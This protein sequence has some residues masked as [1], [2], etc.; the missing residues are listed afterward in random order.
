MSEL[1]EW[2]WN[3]ITNYQ[4]DADSTLG[5]FNIGGAGRWQDKAAIGLPVAFSDV[6]GSFALD[7]SNPIF[8]GSEFNADLWIG[9]KRR[10]WDDKIDWKLQLNLRNVI[11]EDGLIPIAA[12]PDG[13]IINSR[14]P[15]GTIWELSSRFSF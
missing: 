14:I 11:G 7:P 10:I 15:Q 13:T 4:F 12:A 6:L 2:R 1:R 5:G 3:F 8:G 9:Y